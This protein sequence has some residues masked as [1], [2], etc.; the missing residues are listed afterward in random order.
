M[1]K[2]TLHCIAASL[3]GGPIV[4]TGFSL[5]SHQAGRLSPVFVLFFAIIGGFL[6]F[7][8][9]GQAFFGPYRSLNKKMKEFAFLFLFL[10]AAVLTVAL[11]VP[12][13]YLSDAGF[14]A[15]AAVYAAAFLFLLFSLLAI[16]WLSTLLPGPDEAA[17]PPKRTVLLYSAPPMLLSLLY[18]WAFFPGILVIDSVNQWQQAHSIFFNDWHPVVM[19]WIIVLTTKLWDNPAAFVILQLVCADLI[20]GYVIYAFRKMGTNKWMITAGWLFLTFFPLSALYSVTIWK[21]TLYCYFLLLLTT[22]LIQIIRSEGKWLKSSIHLL[23]LYLSIAGL[24]FFRHNG[25]PVLL[26]LFVIFPFFFRK[27]YLRMYAVFLAAVVSFL[28]VT[29]PVFSYF[30]VFPADKLE[31]LAIPVQQAGGIIKGNGEMTAAQKQYFNHI[32]PLSRWKQKYQPTQVDSVKFSTGFNKNYIRQNPAAFALNWSAIVRQNPVIAAKSFLS[33]E[34]LVYKL[35][36]PQS[37]MR[38]IF[39]YKA[40][41]SYRPVYF[42]SPKTVKRYHIHYQTFYYSKYGTQYANT[43][44]ASI[45]EDYDSVFLHGM[46]RILVLPALYLY[47]TIVLLFVVVL[48]G[49]WKLLLAALPA[50]LNLGTIFAAIP[51]QDPRYLFSNYLLIVPFFFLISLIGKKGE[52]HV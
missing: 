29:V 39:R 31:S 11:K 23:I 16:V 52:T 41:N 45:I 47:L 12:R 19:T 1:N 10:F 26:A 13:F 49:Q 35:N 27:N 6:C 40:F 22:V 48:K 18:L 42:L 38:P 34:Q 9:A 17:G 20:S 46:A 28:I 32:F 21:D 25:W 37:E 15:A 4:G 8:V 50:A 30:K 7:G 44:L 36:I 14:F 5:L 2:Q 43:G 33:M 51:A 3:I 24:I